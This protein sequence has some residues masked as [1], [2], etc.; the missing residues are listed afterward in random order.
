MEKRAKKMSVAELRWSIGD[1]QETIR[2]FPTSE[3]CGYY[4]DEIHVYAAELKRRREG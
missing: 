1:C 3:N 2:V 4:M